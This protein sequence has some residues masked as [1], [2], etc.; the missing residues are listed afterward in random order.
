MCRPTTS[1]LPAVKS[2]RGGK[3]GAAAARIPEIDVSFLAKDGHLSIFHAL[4]KILYN[5]RN[6]A[7]ATDQNAEGTQVTALLAHAY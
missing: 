6:D 7:G 2:K 4:G 5:K 1:H 3:R